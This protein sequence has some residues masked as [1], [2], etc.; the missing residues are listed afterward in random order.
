MF[1]FGPGNMPGMHRAPQINYM[2]EY[3]L[4]Y[5]KIASL[6]CLLCLQGGH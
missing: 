5:N 1:G 6:P 2:K 4:A 3:K